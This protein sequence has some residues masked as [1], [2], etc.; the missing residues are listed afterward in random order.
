MLMLFLKKYIKKG[1]A[2]YYAR[3]LGK[4]KLLASTTIVQN[5]YAGFLEHYGFSKTLL[6]SP[7]APNLYQLNLYKKTLP[8]RTF[9]LPRA[10][11]TAVEA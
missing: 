10:S 2:Y 11:C 6:K 9:T 1:I 5:S 4:K 8:R 7:A 3:Y